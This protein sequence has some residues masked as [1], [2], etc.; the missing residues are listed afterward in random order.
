MKAMNYSLLITIIILLALM[1]L[2][3]SKL[4]KWIPAP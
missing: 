1:I 3:L 4:S 2:V